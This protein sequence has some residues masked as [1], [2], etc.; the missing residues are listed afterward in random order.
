MENDMSVPTAADVL[1]RRLAAIRFIYGD[2]AEEA[3]YLY[4]AAWTTY[5]DAIDALRNAIK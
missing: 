3:D 2:E 1:A 5:D 4:E